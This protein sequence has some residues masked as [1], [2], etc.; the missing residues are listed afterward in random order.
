MRFG[1]T[2]LTLLSFSYEVLGLGF[3]YGNEFQREQSNEANNFHNLAQ[4]RFAPRPANIHATLTTKHDPTNTVPL[5]RDDTSCHSQ[6]LR[7]QRRVRPGSFPNDLAFATS[8]TSSSTTV[9]APTATPTPSSPNKCDTTMWGVNCWKSATGCKGRGSATPK[10]LRCL[11]ENCMAQYTSR[12]TIETFCQLESAT[13]SY[14]KG[15]NYSTALTVTTD[16]WGL[17]DRVFDERYKDKSLGPLLT[18]TD[19]DTRVECTEQP[20]TKNCTGVEGFN[21]TDP[22]GWIYSNYS[23]A[24]NNENDC[25]RTCRDAGKK[26]QI[27]AWAIWVAMLGAWAV[28]ILAIGLHVCFGKKWK[29]DMTLK[30]RL[31]RRWRGTPRHPTPAQETQQVATS[32]G[33][34]TPHRREGSDPDRANRAW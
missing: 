32:E 18:C 12:I 30:E 13:E 25:W 34:T 16:H 24:C 2:S 29:D 28:A 6:N 7:S 4:V 5:C 33:R 1:L 22:A 8:A 14:M 31:M 3:H 23:K 11:I 21:H 15:D 20:E 27:A 26:F 10:P 19:M 9:D 17:S